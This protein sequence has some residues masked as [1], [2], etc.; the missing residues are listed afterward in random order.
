[1]SITRRQSREINRQIESNKITEINQSNYSYIRKGAKASNIELLLN[2]P[3]SKDISLLNLFPKDSQSIRKNKHFISNTDLEQEITWNYLLVKKYADKVKMFIDK[4]DVFEKYFFSGYY[5][6]A[7][8]VLK[9]VEED[10]CISDWGIEMD[11]LTTYRDKGHESRKY[12]EYFKYI[13]N[14]QEKNSKSSPNYWLIHLQALRTEI[15]T[16]IR[17]NSFNEKYKPFIDSQNEHDKNFYNYKIGFYNYIQ[18]YSEISL[19]KT[20]DSSSIIDR[21]ETLIFIL[22]YYFCKSSNSTTPDWMCKIIKDLYAITEDSRLSNTM[23]YLGYADNINIK[24]KDIEYCKLIDMY[25]THKY[26]ESKEYAKELLIKYP[27]LFDLYKIYSLSCI[28]TNSDVG[29]VFAKEK[30]LGQMALNNIFTVLRKKEDISDNVNILKNFYLSLG[31][32]SWAVKCCTF[33]NNETSIYTENFRYRLFS[34]LYDNVFYPRI[35]RH[36]GKK[37]RLQAITQSS[38]C[39]INKNINFILYTQVKCHEFNDLYINYTPTNEFREKIIYAQVLKSIKKYEIAYNIY[40]EISEDTSY[41]SLLK[42]PHNNIKL[43]HGKMRCLVELERYNEALSL[44][45]NTILEYPNYFLKLKY[46]TLLKAIKDNP[47]KEI[48]HNICTPIYLEFCHEDDYNQWYAL[49]NFMDENKINHPHEIASLQEFNIETKKHLLQYVCNKKVIKFHTSKYKTHAQVLGECIKIQDILIDIDKN[50]ANYYSN[51]IISLTMENEAKQTRSA[52]NQGKIRVNIEGL[53]QDNRY[54]ELRKKYLPLIELLCNTKHA[55]QNG[56]KKIIIENLLTEYFKQM[57][58]E[59]KNIFVFDNDF[60]FDLYLGTRIRHGW[61]QTALRAIFEKYK[62]ITIVDSKTNK[63]LNNDKWRTL[64]LNDDF[65]SIMS[66]FS[67]SIDE[68]IDE[69]YKRILR[70]KTNQIP[71]ALF[72]YD[73][74]DENIKSVE[75]DVSSKLGDFNN[76]SFNIV[77]DVIVKELEKRTSQNIEQ[78]KSYINDVSLKVILQKLD[79]LTTEIEAL[80]GGQTNDLKNIKKNIISCKDEVQKRVIEINSWFSFS[81]DTDIESFSIK[82]IIHACQNALYNHINFKQT[83]VADGIRDI[84]G[85]Y[86]HSMSD[87]FQ[88]LFNNA[89][90]HSELDNEDIVIEVEINESDKYLDILVRNNLSKSINIVERQK[91]ID[92]ILAE[93]K[94][95]DETKNSGLARI[96]KMI[97]KDLQIEDSQISY[98]I[99]ENNAMFNI[100]T[101]SIKVNKEKIYSYENIVN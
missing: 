87:I 77:F 75:N 46:I 85:K 53:K 4:K 14:K 38:V 35:I 73:F 5:D 51:N 50:N 29:K 24:Q 9:N 20:E 19:I 37:E 99:E 43:T 6:R 89:I 36:I 84:K 13:I 61:I 39:K 59:I 42:L 62:L 57:F 26:E 82:D 95:I 94:N 100:M 44:V 71:V 78:V 70:I 1:M 18:N 79:D 41:T 54:E 58:L 22:Q 80:S 33:I 63:Y 16:S 25:T 74:N 34:A 76:D 91:N 64:S 7:N 92:L 56:N 49:G 40:N 45:T 10:I 66:L 67:S 11:I 69:L 21:Y 101:F 60:G 8:E 81:Q 30:C 12:I 17:G 23:L 2:N 90:K 93:T 97:E 47:T 48:R 88:I 86:F 65:Q 27:N 3:K 55:V 68:T 15:A 96:K 32:I 52:L 31:K 28:Y 98:Q 83:I 72:D